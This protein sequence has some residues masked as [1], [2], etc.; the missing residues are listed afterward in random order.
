MYFLRYDSQP[1]YW[2][3][4]PQGSMVCSALQ[5]TAP[6]WLPYSIVWRLAQLVK[7]GVV[8]DLSYV[9]SGNPLQ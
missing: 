8:I 1:A 9:T 7:D 6:P 2:P 5:G 3:R 4:V